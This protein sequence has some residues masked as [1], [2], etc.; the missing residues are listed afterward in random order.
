MSN[1]KDKKRRPLAYANGLQKNLD[2]LVLCVSK[3]KK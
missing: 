2:A 3:K 1:R